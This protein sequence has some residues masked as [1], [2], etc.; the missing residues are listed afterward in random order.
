[1]KRLKEFYSNILQLRKEGKTHLIKTKKNKSYEE[2]FVLFMM[3]TIKYNNSIVIN[4]KGQNNIWIKQYFDIKLQLLLL[5][6]YT[7]SKI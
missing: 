3:K 4:K 7:E 5:S 1:M 2:E 6:D